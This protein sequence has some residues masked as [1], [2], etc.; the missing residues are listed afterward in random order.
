MVLALHSYPHIVALCLPF[1]VVAAGLA[2]GLL[3]SRA[4]DVV[5]EPGD[6]RRFVVADAIAYGGTFV[7]VVVSLWMR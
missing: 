2:I 4:L 6:P 1:A 3:L 7:A 5:L